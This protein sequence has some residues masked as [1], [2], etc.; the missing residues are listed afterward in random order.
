[1]TGRFPSETAQD[2]GLLLSQ[3]RKSIRY[4][5]LQN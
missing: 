4:H 3:I 5:E 1:M 2:A